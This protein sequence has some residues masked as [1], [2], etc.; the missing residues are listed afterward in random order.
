MTHQRN[1]NQDVGQY[2]SEGIDSLHDGGDGGEEHR[3]VHGIDIDR[4]DT[5][6]PRIMN[7]ICQRFLPVE[8]LRLASRFTRTTTAITRLKM[9]RA[10][11]TRLRGKTGGMMPSVSAKSRKRVWRKTTTITRGNARAPLIAHCHLL[12][13]SR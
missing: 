5:T 9:H 3:L 4:K 10:A 13:K 12:R 8:A 7:L 1:A 2:H 11:P 6:T